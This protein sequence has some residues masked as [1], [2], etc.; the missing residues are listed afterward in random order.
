MLNFLTPFFPPTVLTM[1]DDV[2]YTPVKMT[3]RTLSWQR[4]VFVVT[5]CNTLDSD[6]NILKGQSVF[7]PV[8]HHLKEDHKSLPAILHQLNISGLISYLCKRY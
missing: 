1:M 6:W 2:T 7:L 5:V 3:E 8:E 4:N